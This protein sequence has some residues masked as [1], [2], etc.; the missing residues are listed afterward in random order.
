MIDAQLYRS[1]I[2]VAPAIINKILQRK[3]MQFKLHESK[4]NHHEDED[5]LKKALNN[6]T[7]FQAFY[8]LM[9]LLIIILNVW[10]PSLLS[11]SETIDLHVETAQ[12][13]L[14]C[15]DIDAAAERIFAVLCEGLCLYSIGVVHFI[16]ILLLIAG[17][18]PNP[19][20]NG[21]K[22]KNT[23]EKSSS[24]L[25]SEGSDDV[26]LNAKCISEDATAVIELKTSPETD[27]RLEKASSHDTSNRTT[28]RL[29]SLK[30]T[31][32][33]EFKKRK[34]SDDGASVTSETSNHDTTDDIFTEDDLPHN[35]ETENESCDK[36]DEAV[37]LLKTSQADIKPQ[38]TGKEIEMAEEAKEPIPE[39]ASHFPK[40][41]GSLSEHGN[42]SKSSSFNELHEEHDSRKR[43][44]KY[45]DISEETIGSLDVSLAGENV[46]P[47]VVE[48]PNSPALTYQGSNR[49]IMQNSEIS[50]DMFL[51]R[52]SDIDVT[53][54]DIRT[55][56]FS[57]SLFIS[58]SWSEN[59]DEIIDDYMRHP[60]LQSVAEWSFNYVRLARQ[61]EDTGLSEMPN[62]F[63][64]IHHQRLRKLH[65][66]NN[67]I[68]TI[69]DS[70]LKCR[71]IVDLDLSNNQLSTLP[72]TFR[73]P[74]LR[75]LNLEGNPMFEVPGVLAEQEKL[76]LLKVGS[77]VTR[78]IP[79]SL[80]RKEKI[81]L[82]MHLQYAEFLRAP[83]PT[84]IKS[85]KVIDDTEKT[86]PHDALTL[87]SNHDLN[88]TGTLKKYLD[89]FKLRVAETRGKSNM[90]SIFHGL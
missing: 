57:H 71:F 22:D 90:I 12:Y 27:Q 25:G 55:V 41:S 20:P 15:A 54:D 72:D 5:L 45:S 52:L 83:V 46:R 43:L 75:I 18:E 68:R 4:C 3:S 19:G 58:L 13:S 37:A 31:I 88:P 86:L 82:E 21:H 78:S 7:F 76:E 38:S 10:R 69:R 56:D 74:Q 47:S 44:S 42:Q 84:I 60:D 35:M 9:I 2:G 26:S 14:T 81:T 59:L 34:S 49:L 77:S 51:T 70:F 48:T 23:K 17:I 1:R 28:G 73:F 67:N 36:L 50:K 65:I 16:S 24:D 6:V 87:L 53:N 85:L 64:E 39:D 80:L 8:F 62:C 66:T 32:S 79:P 11:G 40:V 29:K 61:A 33:K 63:G 30:R 89:D